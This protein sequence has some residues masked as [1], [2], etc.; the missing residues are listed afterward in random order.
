LLKIF[1]L[2]DH[3]GSKRDCWINFGIIWCHGYHNLP[4][5]CFRPGK[6]KCTNN[7]GRYDRYGRPVVVLAPTENAHTGLGHHHT[8]FGHHQTEFGRMPYL[9]DQNSFG[10]SKMVLV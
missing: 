4:F 8:E 9:C 5:F 7:D 1:A 6:V 3:V 2:P 10:R